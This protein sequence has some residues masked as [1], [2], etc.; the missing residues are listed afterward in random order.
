MKIRTGFVSNSSSVSFIIK[1]EYL[2]NEQIS[3]IKN[4][5]EFANEGDAW[6]IEEF[7]KYGIPYL[8]GDTSMNNFDMYEYF[9]TI[10]IDQNLVEW[11]E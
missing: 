4:H 5:A 10:K 1:M 3:K 9:D 2:T 11:S 6:F 8:R 7:K